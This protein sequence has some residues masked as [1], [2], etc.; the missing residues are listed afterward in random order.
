MSTAAMTFD[1]T[2]RKVVSMQPVVLSPDI[3]TNC[4]LN[5]QDHP[6]YFSREKETNCD[7]LV[8]AQPLDSL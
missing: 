2:K 1:R 3:E 4:G 6:G 7:E 8:A 5:T